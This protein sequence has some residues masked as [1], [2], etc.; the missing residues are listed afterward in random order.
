MFLK[1]NI[2]LF[3]H[4]LSTLWIFVGIG[5]I[6]YIF[7]CWYESKKDG[8]TYES[9]IDL[10]LVGIILSTL[11]YLGSFALYGFLGVYVYNSILLKY[12]LFYFV[13]TLSIV[14]WYFVIL[15]YIYIKRWSL[16]R[17]LD[18]LYLALA[19]L[20]LPILFGQFVLSY[21]YEYLIQFFYLYIVYSLVYRSKTLKMRS[22]YGFSFGVFLIIPLIVSYYKFSGYLLFASILFT[23][24]LL[25]LIF[26][27]KKAMQNGGLTT[28]FL[29]FIKEKLEKKD[30]EL[31]GQQDL[32]TAEDPY[33]QPGRDEGN[34]ED[35]DEAILED[36]RKEVTDKSMNAVTSLRDQVKK[37][38]SYIKDGKYG[39]CEVCGKP[40]D[41][42]RLEIYPEATKCL[43]CSDKGVDNS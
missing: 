12:H 25:G 32:L 18:T 4:S 37:A 13:S 16:Y 20:A 15:R 3:T 27:R 39:M 22:G 17:T 42:A 11:I 8:F 10:G 14:T 19:N 26:R 35:M 28:D 9:F 41:K 24:A 36:G 34:A 5:I 43:N 6:L 38:L 31:K 2:I 1:P 7:T 40:I 29:N 21:K 23:I 33:M 30:A